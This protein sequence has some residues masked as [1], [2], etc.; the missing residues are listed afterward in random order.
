MM[1][2]LIVGCKKNTNRS[3]SSGSGGSI[4]IIIINNNK[5]KKLLDLTAYASVKRGLIE[6]RASIFTKESS[7]LCT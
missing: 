2:K 1:I 4:I 7:V 5:K 3:Y 6:I